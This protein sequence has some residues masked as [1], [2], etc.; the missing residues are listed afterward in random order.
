MNDGEKVASDGG[1]STGENGGEG[2]IN[3][4]ADLAADLTDLGLQRPRIL[5]PRSATLIL[6]RQIVI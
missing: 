5:F 6:D 2:G 3:Q 1:D 4:Q